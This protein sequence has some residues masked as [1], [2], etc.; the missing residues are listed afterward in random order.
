MKELDRDLR[1]FRMQNGDPVYIRRS[2][3]GKAIRAY[4]RQLFATAREGIYE[5][6]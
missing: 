4:E 6:I 1:I 5:K 3:L 2:S